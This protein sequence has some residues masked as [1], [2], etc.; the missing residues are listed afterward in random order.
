[1]ARKSVDYWEER[2]TELMLMLEKKTEETIDDLIQ[3]Y[4]QATRNINKEIRDI[5]KNF[6]KDTGLSKET[7]VQLLN[8]KETKTHYRNLLDVINNHITDDGIK[9]KLLAKYNAPAYAYRISRYQALQENID[10]ELSKLAN[11]EEQ[12]TKIRYID[13]IEERIL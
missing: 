5:Y 3:I 12:I 13:T 1:M 6:A 8:R 7:L 10:I 11:L 9:K 2:N 4:R